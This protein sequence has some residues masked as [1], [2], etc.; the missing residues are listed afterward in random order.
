MQSPKSSLQRPIGQLHLTFRCPR[1]HAV[2]LWCIVLG[3]GV[4]TCVLPVLFHSLL[5]ACPF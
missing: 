3:Y 1:V 5:T 4:V 2:G